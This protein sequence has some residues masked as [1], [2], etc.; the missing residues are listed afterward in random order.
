MNIF[1]Y[2]FPVFCRFYS[3]YVWFILNYR[4]FKFFIFLSFSAVISARFWQIWRVFL[5]NY[6][7][8][9]LKNFLAVDSKWFSDRNCSFSKWFLQHF[10]LVRVHS[11]FSARFG[12]RNLLFASRIGEVLNCFGAYLRSKGGEKLIF[13][14][15]WG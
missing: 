12:F 5:P 14:L 15:V 8:F 11:E 1:K 7:E 10:G 9:G 3:N 4:F 2:F 13:S 6:V